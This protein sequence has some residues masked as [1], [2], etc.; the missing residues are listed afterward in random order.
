MKK[1]KKKVLNEELELHWKSIFLILTLSNS[2]CN[3]SFVTICC[4]CG[5]FKKC[6]ESFNFEVY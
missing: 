4:I 1:K 3:A 6:H 2:K 5:Y